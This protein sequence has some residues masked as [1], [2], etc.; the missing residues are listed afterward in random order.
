MSVLNYPLSNA[1]MELLKLFNTNLSD[2]D[3]VELKTLL[4]SFYAEKAIAQADD[5]WDKKGLSDEDM[6]NW[7]NQKS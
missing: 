4:S 3:L 5:I 7:L 6:D 1:Q 2:Q